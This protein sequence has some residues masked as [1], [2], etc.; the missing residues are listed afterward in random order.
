MPSLDA[1]K[2]SQAIPRLQKQV[3]IWLCAVRAVI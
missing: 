1:E 2:L 3:N